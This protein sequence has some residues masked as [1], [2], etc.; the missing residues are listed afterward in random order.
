[1]AEVL[2]LYKLIILYMLHKVDFP[3]TNSQITEFILEREYTNYFTV[4]QAF[5][6]AIDANLIRT[7]NTYQR[8]IYHLT[9]EGEQTIQFFS[10]DI[11]PV[12]RE[13]IAAYLEERKY[14]LRNDTNIIADYYRNTNQEYSVNLQ[15]KEQQELLLDLTIS[16]P[17]EAVAESI[18]N[19]WNK[20]NQEVYALIM[21]QLL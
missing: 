7:E 12:I 16:V 5:A 4:Q 17:T 11:S 2:T 21:E 20:K 8:T 14:D 9:E 13:E 6:E 10:N 15:I 18:A 1:M 19:N 3:L